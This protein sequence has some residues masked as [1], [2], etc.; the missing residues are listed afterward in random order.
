MS[1][2]ALFIF[3]NLFCFQFLTSVLD[4]Q[5]PAQSHVRYYPGH[6]PPL[7]P[8]LSVRILFR[9]SASEYTAN[10]AESF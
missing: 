2:R 9:P 4:T 1:K 7:L 5:I 10:I 3:C 6:Q 8:F